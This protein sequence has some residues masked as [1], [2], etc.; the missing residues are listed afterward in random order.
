MRILVKI[1]YQNSTFLVIFLFTPNQWYQKGYI[2]DKISLALNELY[3]FSEKCSQLNS[4]PSSHAKGSQSSFV[5][6]LVSR[7]SLRQGRVWGAGKTT[8]LLM[9]RHSRFVIFK[10]SPGT[11]ME[12]RDE[13]EKINRKRRAK[14]EN[15]LTGG[16]QNGEG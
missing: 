4:S 12:H 13:Y 10:A 7:P 1:L 16:E 5:S 14:S 3:T 9:N 2:T 15:L 8:T 11:I 6:H